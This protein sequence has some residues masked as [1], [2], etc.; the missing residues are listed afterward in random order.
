MGYPFDRKFAG[1]LT[2]TLANLPHAAMRTLT[3]KWVGPV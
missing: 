1:T 3:I 2:Q